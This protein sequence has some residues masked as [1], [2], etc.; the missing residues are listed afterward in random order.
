MEQSEN[1]LE[2]GGDYLCTQVRLVLDDPIMPIE[3]PR[4]CPDDTE[5][6]RTTEEVQA[7][8]S[9]LENELESSSTSPSNLLEDE[10]YCQT[11]TNNT[12]QHQECKLDFSVL[13]VNYTMEEACDGT[14]LYLESE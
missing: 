14:G 9:A 6:I 13:P 1:T 12:G 3:Q 4:N 8:I 2:V 11:A 10:T 5:R 7:A